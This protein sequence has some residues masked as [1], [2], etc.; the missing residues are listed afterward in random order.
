MREPSRVRPAPIGIVATPTPARTV[1]I[2]C[3][4]APP[5]DLHELAGEDKP[6]D[7]PG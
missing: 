2:R 4:D 6:A 1:E 5:N 7:F 3:A